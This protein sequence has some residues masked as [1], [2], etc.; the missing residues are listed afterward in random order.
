MK[1]LNRKDIAELLGLAAIVASLV[2]VGVQMRQ[3][4]D[5][6]IAEGYSSLFA[7]RIEVGNSIK[8]HVDIWKKGTAGEKLQEKD[9]AIFAILVNQLN[10]N[11]VQAYL[12]ASMVEGKDAAEFS[13]RNFA[14]FLYHNPGARKVWVDR[15]EHLLR[16]RSLLSDEDASESWTE[17]VQAYLSKLDRAKPPI[18]AK[19]IAAW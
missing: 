11:A 17:S 4:Q 9:L 5:I 2:F 12:H 1:S 7:A 16:I 18:D 19:P 13:A 15:E 8:E 10:E 14:G 6:A 3:T